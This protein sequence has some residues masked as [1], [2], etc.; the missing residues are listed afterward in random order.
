M[1]AGRIAAPLMSAARIADVVARL[2]P[3]VALVTLTAG[4]GSPEA[5]RT[6]GHGPGADVGNRRAIV[7]FHDG[8][9]IYYRTPC[10][11]KVE[12]KGPPPVFGTS[13]KPD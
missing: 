2:A 6:R 3:L 8:A 13:W 4:C 9:R 12:C 1:S 10:V 5:Q 7:V 11:T